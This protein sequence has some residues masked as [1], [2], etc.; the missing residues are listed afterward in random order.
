MIFEC[1]QI[2]RVNLF[3]LADSLVKT[4]AGF[5]AEPAALDHFLVKFREQKTLAPGIVRDRA[6]EIRADER[7]DIEADDIDQAKAC[8]TRKADERPGDR[9]DFF[10][11]VTAFE[12]VL[13]NGAA[14][15]AA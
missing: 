11:R 10:H 4:L 6:E 13:L 2:N 12:R 1:L 8:A 15:E 9:V 14:E 5:V 3:I 7:P